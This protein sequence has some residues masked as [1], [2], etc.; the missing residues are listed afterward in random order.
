MLH[1]LVL[2]CPDFLFIFF[3]GKH[4]TWCWGGGGYMEECFPNSGCQGIRT[5]LPVSMRITVSAFLM[6]LELRARHVWVVGGCLT[7]LTRYIMQMTSL[8]L[9]MR[10][11]VFAF[12]VGLEVRAS[13]IWGRGRLLSNANTVYHANDVTFVAHAQYGLCLSSG[14]RVQTRYLGSWEIA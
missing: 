12:L 14:P 4:L 2:M 11:T 3:V 8:S 7:T 1:P 10:S 5:V 9:R 6:V 13:Y